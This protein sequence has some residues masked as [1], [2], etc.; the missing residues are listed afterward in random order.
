MIFMLVAVVVGL[1]FLALV[2]LLVVSIV[3]TARR[4]QNPGGT[5]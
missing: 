5:P 3:R 1:A 2:T 4:D